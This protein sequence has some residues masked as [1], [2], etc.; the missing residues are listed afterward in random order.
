MNR[1]NKNIFVSRT[2]YICVWFCAPCR[3]LSVRHPASVWRVWQH[4]EAD[5]A[6][7]GWWQLCDAIKTKQIVQHNKRRNVIW[8]IIEIAIRENFHLINDFGENF[9]TFNGC[10]P[11][12]LLESLSTDWSNTF[13]AGDDI[14]SLSLFGR[15]RSKAQYPEK[16]VRL[17]W[18]N[19]RI[20]DRVIP[21]RFI[22][23]VRNML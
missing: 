22:K 14:Q 23:N 10:S 13:S 5:Q 7:T 15:D 8:T 11:V 17:E 19:N 20:C 4:W 2:P 9:K 21:E 3:A 1:K 6:Q 18:G 16:V 12:W